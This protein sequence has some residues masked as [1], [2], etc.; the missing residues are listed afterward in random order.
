MARSIADG[1]PDRVVE[2]PFDLA[3]DQ[4]DIPEHEPDSRFMFHAKRIGTTLLVGAALAG[5]IKVG[6]MI[7]GKNGGEV[8]H[9]NV[10]GQVQPPRTPDQQP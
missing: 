9:P 10:P 2:G 8:P 1:F 5:A 4:H 6:D 7:L 3:K